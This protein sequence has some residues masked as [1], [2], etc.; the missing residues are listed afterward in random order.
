M[1]WFGGQGGERQQPRPGAKLTRRSRH[2]SVEAGGVHLPA[3]STEIA[4]PQD[5]KL[6]P[7]AP[8]P[9]EPLEIMKATYA[10]TSPFYIIAGAK[11]S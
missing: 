6:T 2:L 7:L 5:A 10:T 11:T 9:S 1:T 3:P 8:E 4:A